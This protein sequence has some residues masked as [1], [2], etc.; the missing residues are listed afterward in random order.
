M[1]ALV[2]GGNGFIGSF[3][4]E[5]LLQKG[6]AVRCLVR[7]TSNLRWIKNL[8]V[9]F[10]YADLGEPGLLQEA[11]KEMDWVFHLAGLTK[12]KSESEFF[13][14]NVDGTKNLLVAS[15]NS[16]S[17]KKFIFI[18][19]Q[20]AGGPS[21]SAALKTEFDE[22]NPISIY[23]KSKRAAEQAVLEFGRKFPVTIIRPP[24]VYGPREA[25]IFKIFKIINSGI[26]PVIGGGAHKISVVHVFDLIKGILLAA[27]NS[28]AD[29]KIF[30]ISGDGAYSWYEIEMLI[31]SAL[32]RRVIPLAIP[33]FI[34]E[35]I[36]WLKINPMLNKDKIA[37][38]RQKYWLCDNRRA[39]Q[40]MGFT[41]EISLAQGLHE[42][43][44]WYKN[45]GWL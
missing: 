43:A 6:H 18:S 30:Y 10:F 13:R 7:S 25:E 8:P 20:A 21:A 28:A 4:A 12:A 14:V 45:E 40:E 5:R 1:K 23:G 31:A 35:I 36:R 37:E 34:L 32:R 15:Q 2:T 3:L 17:L 16:L 39:K 41:P 19:S 42:T 22:S 27:E 33:F 9:D 44:E 24:S 29:G 26:L 11:V 38:I